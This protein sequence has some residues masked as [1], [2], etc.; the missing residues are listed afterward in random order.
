MLLFYFIDGI[1][2]HSTNI[3]L[4]YMDY[5]TYEIIYQARERLRNL[6]PSTYLGNASEMA[7]RSTLD[8]EQMKAREIM[9]VVEGY[10]S[11]NN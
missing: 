6:T 7:K 2:L 9:V 5:L 10:E 8:E 11:D 1:D 4:L 3:Y